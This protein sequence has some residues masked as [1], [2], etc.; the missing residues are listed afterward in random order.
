MA[1]TL[2]VASAT[3][4]VYNQIFVLGKITVYNMLTEIQKLISSIA[5]KE[6]CPLRLWW[7]D[8]LCKVNVNGDTLKLN[9]FRLEIQQMLQ[10]TWK[11]YN[12]IS[13]GN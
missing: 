5:Y 12:N 1:K 4:G 9:S 11:L 2:C 8:N 13:R 7:S 10:A 3:R 6:V